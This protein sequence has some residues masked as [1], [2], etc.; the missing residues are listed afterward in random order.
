MERDTDN[1]ETLP[2]IYI[3]R[4][5]CRSEL[6]LLHYYPPVARGALYGFLIF[7][8]FLSVSS[9]HLGKKIFIVRVIIKSAASEQP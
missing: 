3:F 5:Q 1:V 8:L 9:K 2:R 6:L 4:N 7:F